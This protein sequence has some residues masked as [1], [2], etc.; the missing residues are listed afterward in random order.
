MIYKEDTEEGFL[1][2]TIQ[3]NSPLREKPF[4]LSFRNGTEPPR[5]YRKFLQEFLV[6]FWGGIGHIHYFQFVGKTVIIR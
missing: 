2:N 5:S 1:S 4:S 6:Q 3:S